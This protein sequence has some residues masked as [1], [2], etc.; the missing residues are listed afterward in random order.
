MDSHDWDQRY[1]AA[2]LVWSAEP[3]LFVRDEVAP[4]APGK[5]LDLAAGEG[6]NSLW[7]ASAGWQ[8]TAVDFSAVAIDKGRRLA[9]RLADPAAA[10][11]I[12]WVVADLLSYEP[13]EAA[14]DLVLLCY[15]QLPSLERRDVLARACRALAPSGI[16]LVIGHALSNLSGGTGGPQDPAVL[17]DP[18]DVLAELPGDI[19]LSI[20]RAELVRRP[21]EGAQDAIDTLV[22]A[23]RSS[24]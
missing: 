4:L 6:R 3:N 1:A 12:D 22:R 16:L 5:A 20:E 18:D 19:A 11:R 7:M 23:R 13:P 14:F 17:Y 21:I 2:E 10:Q 24:A 9:E 15:L 8:V